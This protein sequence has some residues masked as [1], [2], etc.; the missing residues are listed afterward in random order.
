M[1]RSLKE[2][3][4]SS[5][6]LRNPDYC[7]QFLVQTDASQYG[8]GAV[9][10]QEGDD[11]QDHPIIYI[12]SKLLPREQKYSAIEKECLAIVWAVQTLR[13]Y[14]QGYVFIVQT[15]HHPL[16]WLGRMRNNNARL[17]RWSL[18]LQPFTL[19][20]HHRPGKENANADSLSRLYRQ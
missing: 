12:S 4:C 10:S 6:V 20:V 14:L 2:A 7:R 15:D 11:G 17:T 3:L 9:L 19:E 18:A 1:R 16:Q 13:F 5:P 8:I